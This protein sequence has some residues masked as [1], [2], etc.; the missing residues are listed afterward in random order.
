M[1]DSNANCFEPIDSPIDE[2]SRDSGTDSPPTPL[3]VAA[4]EDLSDEEYF[5]LPSVVNLSQN[6]WELFVVIDPKTL[7]VLSTDFNAVSISGEENNC[8]EECQSSLANLNKVIG[9]DDSLNNYI[10]GHRS[11]SFRPQPNGSLGTDFMINYSNNYWTDSNS[12]YSL[13]SVRSRTSLPLS[14]V[15]NTLSSPLV[16]SKDRSSDQNLCIF[17]ALTSSSINN[18]INNDSN[19]LK[20]LSK[21]LTNGNEVNSGSL[22]ARKSVVTN[23]VVTEQKRPRVVLRHSRLLKRISIDNKF[24]P[25][26]SLHRGLAL[27][28]K[29]SSS[30][31]DYSPPS[32]H[33]RSSLWTRPLIS[34]EQVMRMSF[35][36][37]LK[38]LAVGRLTRSR[39][40]PLKLLRASNKK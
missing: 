32:K 38:Q 17:G 31:S 23:G 40:R 11:G 7:S 24:S 36:R 25:R 9:S 2:S 35:T 1:Y 15:D 37:S 10:Y 16:D 21:V 6:E 29:H 8:V 14:Y 30:P 18:A 28:R 19:Y 13:P 3:A 33:L 12:F 5:S 34:R 4:G 26:A 20:K 27:K 39:L 22:S